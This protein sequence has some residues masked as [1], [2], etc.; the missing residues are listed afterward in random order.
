MHGKLK[1][2]LLVIMAFIGIGDTLIMAPFSS[3]FNLGILLPGL[4]GIVLLLYIANQKYHYLVIRNKFV[5]RALWG[6]FVLW[7]LSFIGMEVFL[8]V[9]SRNEVSEDV[10]YLIILG[11]GLHGSEMSLSLQERMNAGLEYLIQHQEMQVV[12]SGGQ[13]QGEDMSEA[14]AMRDYLLLSGISANR[15]IVEDK[16]TS[17][18]ENFMYSSKLLPQA[19][20]Q[21]SILIVTNDFHMFRA[22]LLAGRCGFS[23]YGLPCRTPL[24]V[25]PNC[26]LREYF[27][28]LKSI[29]MDRP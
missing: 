24:P 18:L 22:K 12:V 17:T 11:A 23:A 28:V 27:A 14:A 7:L 9:E 4:T 25:L 2:R 5:K 21:V 1:N 15:I 10:D 20:Q 19:E 6:I 26:Y 29:V 16:P 8:I 13:G 3:I